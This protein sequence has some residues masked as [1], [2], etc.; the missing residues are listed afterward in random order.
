MEA[1]KSLAKASDN[2]AF[3]LAGCK[4]CPPC[5]HPL[6]CLQAGADVPTLAI[7]LSTG[8]PLALHTQNLPQGLLG[9]LQGVLEHGSLDT[10][11]WSP[12]DIKV[13][14]PDSFHSAPALGDVWVPLRLLHASWTP[15]LLTCVS[16]GHLPASP[17]NSWGL[18]QGHPLLLPL[19]TDR[20]KIAA[21]SVQA[22]P[23]FG[24]TSLQTSQLLCGIISL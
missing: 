4:V 20:V 22:E 24:V 23:H 11:P 21:T 5:C 13:T 18:E 10:M 9:S 15:L 3:E 12:W 16:R 2:E 6:L 8:W 14:A 17:Q 7:N 19:G 1:L